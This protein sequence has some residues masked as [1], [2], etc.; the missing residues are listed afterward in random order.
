MKN[1]VIQTV[2]GP[3]E[4][5]KLGITLMHEHLLIDIPYSWHKPTEASKVA[6][7][8]APVNPEIIGELK[9]DP[10]I[11]LD[12]IQMSD[13]YDATY[14]VMKFKE[15]GG[16]TIVD[17]TSRY[18][19]RDPLALKAIAQRTGLNIVMGG[20]YFLEKSLPDK[21]K[22]MSIEDAKEEV[23]K[24]ITI[25]VDGSEI[26][27]GIIGEAGV[28]INMT[29][30]EVKLLRAQS[31]A[32]VV[33][34]VPLT[35]HTYGWGRPCHKIIDIVAEEGANLKMVI[36]DH[37][38]PSGNDLKYQVSLL[39]RGVFLEY[40][41]IGMDYYYPGEGQSPSDEENA[42]AIKNL[43]DAGYINQILLSQD[44]FLKMM[45]TKYGG[46]GYGYILK[47]FLPRL[48]SLGINDQ[49]IYTL[50]VENPQRVFIGE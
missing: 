22:D 29:D 33:T 36:L 1:T 21:V 6:L 39:E 12:N 17:A 44:V 37:M 26:K 47:H 14:E 23:I 7:A 48:K 2:T 25:G 38:N 11:N 30:V 40:D 42:R 10:Y 16:Q 34:N 43:I 13:I 15:L 3:I 46:N 8:K 28:G 41:M 32:Q 5:N 31:R 49:Q 50:L 18:N 19:G 20:G 4:I 45:L 9:C 24:E 35:I 27:V